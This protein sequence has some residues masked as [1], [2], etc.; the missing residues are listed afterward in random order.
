MR[1]VARSG[2][3]PIT[4]CSTASTSCVAAASDMP[5][6]VMLTA[7]YMPVA[8]QCHAC[9]QSAVRLRAAPAVRGCTAAGA[10]STP[11]GAS[12]GTCASAAVKLENTRLLP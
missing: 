10:A 3:A 7:S 11:K 8:C 2:S 6:D 5:A 1:G 4:A 12:S 9:V